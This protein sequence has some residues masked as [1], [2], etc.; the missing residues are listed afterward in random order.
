[1]RKLTKAFLDFLLWPLCIAGLIVFVW[2]GWRLYYKVVYEHPLAELIET[3]KENGA[4]LERIG[5]AIKELST[6]MNALMSIPTHELVGMASWY[7]KAF[8]GKTTASGRPLD[9]KNLTAAH[10]SLPLGTVV[11]VENLNNR[12]SVELEIIDR[13][14]FYGTRM[15]D[16]SDSAA[17]ALGMKKAGTCPVRITVISLPFRELLSSKLSAAD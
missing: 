3:Q 5:Q 11:R 8:E 17:V 14:P 9:G 4:A 7:G 1:M 6:N 16:L 10:P 12:H 2:G 15:L 13:G